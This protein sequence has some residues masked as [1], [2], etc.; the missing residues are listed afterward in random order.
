MVLAAAGAGNAFFGARAEAGIPSGTP[1]ATAS[2]TTAPAADGP[3]PQPAP[4]DAPRPTL[5]HAATDAATPA[6]SAPSNGGAILAR[7]TDLLVAVATNGSA[8]AGTVNAPVTT[9][10]QTDPLLEAAAG[11]ETV[12]KSAGLREAIGNAWK[13][14]WQKSWPFIKSMTVKFIGLFSQAWRSIFKVVETGN[15]NGSV[16]AATNANAAVNASQ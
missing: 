1:T 15:V 4:E 13:S 11:A 3:A 8:G 16:N 10:A 9:N 6:G 12:A 2:A 14:S 5:D 7:A